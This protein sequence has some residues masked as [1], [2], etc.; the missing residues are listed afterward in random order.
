MPGKQY[1]RIFFGDRRRVSCPCPDR[2][3]DR[4]LDK[5]T[6][7]LK[8]TYQDMQKANATLTERQLKLEK[9]LSSAKKECKDAKKP[10]TSWGRRQF[11]GL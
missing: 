7:A 6:Q 5:E 3:Q 10:L 1:E 11:Q 2:R 9:Q 4:A 8:Q